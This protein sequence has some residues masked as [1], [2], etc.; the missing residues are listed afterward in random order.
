MM[1][2]MMERWK[3]GRMMVQGESLVNGS[4]YHG[5]ANGAACRSGEIISSEN[6][7][8]DLNEENKNV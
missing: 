7:R 1:G 3:D 2:E 6:G 5:T 8:T 4:V